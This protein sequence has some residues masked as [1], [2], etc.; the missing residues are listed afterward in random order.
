MIFLIT[1]GPDIAP[2]TFFLNQF[3][4]HMQMAWEKRK[5]YFHNDILSQ[6]CPD[7]A[8]CIQVTFSLGQGT[9]SSFAVVLLNVPHA[10]LSQ[11][12]PVALIP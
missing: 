5:H 1:S 4:G 12:S 9:Q 6:S 8:P 10:H 7:V 2:Y 3:S 11:P